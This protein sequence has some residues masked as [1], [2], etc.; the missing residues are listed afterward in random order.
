MYLFDKDEKL[1]KY[2]NVNGIIDDFLTSRKAIYQTRKDY[3]LKN[4]EEQMTLYSNK[5]RF[6]SELLNDTLDLRKKKS[7]EINH[8]LE[9]KKYD[10][11]ND[12]YNYLVKMPMDMV[13]EEN[14]ETLKSEFDNTRDQLETLKNTTIETMYLNEI[15]DLEKVV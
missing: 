2:N 8:I 10:K 5:Y 11:Y 3:M 6:I 12:N 4:M 15:G 13:N 7:G 14:V 1:K 9:D